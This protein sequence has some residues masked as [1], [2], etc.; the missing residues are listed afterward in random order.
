LKVLPAERLAD[1]QAVTRFEREMRAGGKLQHP[2]IVAAHDAGE[3]DGTH[4]LVMELVE[5]ADLA[6]LGRDRGPLPIAQACQLDRQA[7]LGLAHA[8]QHG[9]VHRDI[10]P[11]NLMLARAAQSGAPPTVKVLD[12]GLALLNDGHV[13]AAG[14]LTS[15]G[16]VMGTID[17][18]APEQGTDTHMVDIRADIYSLGATLYKLLTG[19]VPFAGAQYDTAV[20]KLM[21]LATKDPPPLESLRRACPP[22]LATLVHQMLG[23]NPDSRPASPATLAAI[24]EPFA[25][26][27]KLRALLDPSF[28][29]DLDSSATGTIVSF[30]NTAA[31]ACDETSIAEPAA[32]P[33][34][35]WAAAPPRRAALRRLLIGLGALAA[36]VALGIIITVATEKGT[37][38][39][40]APEGV[41]FSV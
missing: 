22:A 36:V 6:S 3:I 8:H 9:L 32:A 5:G 2:N 33:T 19:Q 24:L 25:R 16:Q 23:K 40:D 20:K 28:M 34:T 41:N 21:A 29:T 38:E 31:S 1:P 37:V 35:R 30:G 12:L 17:Y 14:E 10:K 13:E 18:M 11:S 7:A 27:A 39:I 26:G 15:T 4:Y